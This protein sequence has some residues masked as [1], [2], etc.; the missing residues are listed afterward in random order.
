MLLMYYCN[1]EKLQGVSWGLAGLCTRTETVTREQLG[2]GV[3]ASQLVKSYRV[4]LLGEKIS[5]IGQVESWEF[6]E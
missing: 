4:E 2:G 6:W 1:G 3:D 5:Q